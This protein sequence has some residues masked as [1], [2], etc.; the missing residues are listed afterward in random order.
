MTLRRSL[1]AVDALATAQHPGEDPAS[2]PALLSLI[3]SGERFEDSLKALD[4]RT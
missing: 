4:S 2:A 1:A 3:Q